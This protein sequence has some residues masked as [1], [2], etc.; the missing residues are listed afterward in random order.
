[1]SEETSRFNLVTKASGNELPPVAIK[2]HLV[3]FYVSVYNLI[4]GLKKN[5][6]SGNG[7]RGG[8]KEKG[9]GSREEGK[10]EKPR[11]MKVRRKREEE[12]RKER[13]QAPAWN[14]H[15]SLEQHQDHSDLVPQGQS[16]AEPLPWTMEILSTAGLIPVP[17]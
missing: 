13:E 5:I 4:N 6:H 8:R 17:P 1:M 3:M 11:E 10:E 16:V 15:A 9:K 2:T 7:E 12:S 14:S